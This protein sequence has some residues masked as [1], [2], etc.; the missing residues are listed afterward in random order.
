[1]LMPAAVVAC[2]L[3]LTGAVFFAVNQKSRIVRNRDSM[4][5]CQCRAVID[6]LDLTE[7]EQADIWTDLASQK[8]SESDESSSPLV[9]Q[10][11][12]MPRLSRSSCM[13]YIVGWY[14]QRFLSSLAR[15][16]NSIPIVGAVV[17]GGVV[18][19]Y[20]V[21]LMQPLV[22]LFTSIADLPVVPIWSPG[23]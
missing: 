4:F 7:G 12:K 6:T 17:A 16:K 1:M 21:A 13:T 2:I 19:L 22:E 20:G 18:L 9:Q 3:L 14:R 11:L 15:R 5:L 10:V 8:K 23:L